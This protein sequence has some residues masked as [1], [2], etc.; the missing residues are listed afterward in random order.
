MGESDDG[1][2]S[3]AAVAVAVAFFWRGT[4]L[5]PPLRRATTIR[6]QMMPRNRLEE[7]NN[8]FRFL[9]FIACSRV[10]VCVSVFVTHQEARG[11]F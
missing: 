4:A 8:Y 3:A 6:R 5:V 2:A 10:M 9:R 11:R 7:R 1:F